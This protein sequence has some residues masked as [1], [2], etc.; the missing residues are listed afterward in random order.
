MIASTNLPLGSPDE[1]NFNAASILRVN[2][3]ARTTVYLLLF[4]IGIELQELTS[5]IQLTHRTVGPLSH[6]LLD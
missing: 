1:S 4:E 3:N 5:R 6:N 2:R